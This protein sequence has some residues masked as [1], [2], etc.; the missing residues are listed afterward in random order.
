MLGL[1][2]EFQYIQCSDCGCL[3]I[4]DKPAD[5]HPYYPA[6]YYSLS[7]NPADKLRN[8]WINALRKQ[9]DTYAVLNRG[10]LGRLLYAL[11]PNTTL[12]PLSRVPMSPSMR[13]LDVGCGTGF[14]LWA[15]H[16]IGITQVA[17][18]DPF[19]E[20][21]LEYPNGITIQKG[22]MHDVKGLWDV[23]IFHHS[24]EHIAN[25]RE[26]LTTVHQHL[27]PGGACILRIP[28]VS[29]WAW[30]HY[31]IYWHQLDAPRHFYLHSLKSIDILAQQT[32]FVVEEVRYDSTPNQFIIAEQYKR[33]IW[34]YSERAWG[35]NP[36]N[37][38]FS[39]RDIRR[40][41]QRTRQLNAQKRGDQA[42]FILRKQ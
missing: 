38:I 5:M 30:E 31:D 42:A 16:Q 10:L 25:P 33:G 34:M 11:M 32:G 21:S 15:L 22:T 13:L 41:K 27:A 35:V 8:P 14:H 7:E 36:A 3:Q 24:F 23:M 28:T 40:F 37:S 20:H 4:V 9:R 17:G 6:E 12:R 26:T 1:E 18:I 19:L 39:K 29:S 2:E